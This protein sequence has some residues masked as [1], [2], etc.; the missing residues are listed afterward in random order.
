MA[1]LESAL[2]W[3]QD[4]WKPLEEQLEQVG[5]DWDA[6]LA[7][8]PQQLGPY[9]RLLRLRDTVLGPLQGVF[10]TRRLWLWKDETQ[11]TLDKQIEDLAG[12]KGLIACKLWEATKQQEP[13]A[14]EDVFSRLTK[15][16]EK[17]KVA[18][19]RSE[20][21]QKLAETAPAWAE[22]IAG[23]QG[24]HRGANVPGNPKDAWRWRQLTEEL[25]ERTSLDERVLL[26]R[27][28]RRMDTLRQIAANLIESLAWGNQL[29]R[30]GL[31]EQQALIGWLETVRKIGKG[32]GKRAR[33]LRAEARKLMSQARSAVPVWIMPI[34]RAVENFDALDTRF[35]VVIVDEASQSDVMGLAVLFMGKKVL[36]VGDHEQVSPS[37]V[38]QKLDVVENLIA[39]YLE[40]IPN[41]H[42]YDGQTSIYDL[43]RTSFGGAIRLVEH[44]RCVPE[45]IDF[46]NWLSYSGEIKPL[47][48]PSTADLKPAVVEFY[49][50]DA[51]SAEK[52]N[53]R[54]AEMTAALLVSATEQHEY[55]DKTFGV[56]SMVGA[57]QARRIEE[58]IRKFLGEKIG[59]YTRQQVLC[60]DAAS[61]QGDERDVMFL[62][63]VDAPGDGPLRLRDT[64]SFRQRFNVA[65][66]RAKDQM[67]I[68][69]SLA[70]D[71]DLKPGDLRKRLIDYARD[72]SARRRATDEAKARAE[73]DFEKKVI[74]WLIA[75]GYSVEAQVSV[76]YYRIDIV[77]H[78][79]NRRVAIECD[80]DRYHPIE[81]IP[82]D[83]ARQAIL[84]RLGWKF[85]RIRGSRFY[86]DQDRTMRAVIEKL[87]ELGVEPQGPVLVKVPKQPE[88]ELKE[89]VIRRA[90]EIVR[91]W[92]GDET[93]L[94]K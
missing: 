83:M 11:R 43:A 26:D 19:E 56:I 79:K 5:F 81:K 25:D 85:V 10:E 90:Y 14:Y 21:L 40:G 60:G 80:G 63:V 93:A 71:V 32:K 41:K 72:P 69:H 59:D 51:T 39:T 46:S 65:A 89:R 30:T 57:E 24:A 92:C 15:L 36:V 17:T 44:F 3:Q 74:E 2:R 73:S 66:S 64:R 82:D 84:R 67:W 58:F 20:L 88:E 49:V 91:E 22:A 45:I 27:L 47:R 76:G 70:P 87:R 4:V 62:S 13:A 8:Q 18:K 33:R 28:E 23:R 34:A 6:F 61:F 52:V 77:V 94:A 53:K 55:R 48:D 7:T 78:G 38:G 29:A 50:R 54:E 68:V 1:P 31:A 9:G 86:R 35:D 12:F 42:L 37:A 16:R 75:A